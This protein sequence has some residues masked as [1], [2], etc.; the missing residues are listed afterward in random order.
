M[1]MPGRD[2]TTTGKRSRHS[3]NGQERSDELNDNLTT[4]LYWEYDSRIMKRWNVDPEL[5]IGESSYLCF[6]ANPIFYSDILGNKASG[7]TDWIK[8]TNADGTTSF[9]WDD[10]AKN[11]ATTPAGYTYVSPAGYNYSA[12]N[13]VIVNLFANGNWLASSGVTAKSGFKDATP[14]SQAAPSQAPSQLPSYTNKQNASFNSVNPY[15]SLTDFERGMIKDNIAT[16]AS[17]MLMTGVSKSIVTKIVA[18]TAIQ[19]G[20]NGKNADVADIAIN[21][22][23]PSPYANVWATSML[24]WKPASGDLT[25]K[26]GFINKEPERV[27]LDLFLNHVYYGVGRLSQVPV[28]SKPTANQALAAST[29]N[30][31][32]KQV[33]KKVFSDAMFPDAGKPKKF[34]VSPFLPDF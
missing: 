6:S 4:A 1:M 34:S 21:S 27:G 19:V 17:I 2:F 18:N 13:N 15:S 8:K 12:G 30:S 28:L 29:I 5:K 14:P 9:K 16:D 7:P 31:A 23:S 11:Q 24:D 33:V 32:S 25:P 3:I 26:V 10:K 22:F 20:V